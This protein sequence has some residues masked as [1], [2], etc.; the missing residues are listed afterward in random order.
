VADACAQPW[1]DDQFDL[2]LALEVLEHIDDPGAAL[3]EIARV[4]RRAA[5]ISVPNEPLW[6]VLNMARGAYLCRFGNTPGHLQHWGA[7]SFRRLVETELEIEDMR[8][9]LPWLM[10]L[11]IPPTSTTDS[12]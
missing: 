1:P 5:I 8:R 6:R 10:A 11:C 9:P 12:S 3:A 4:A 2:V 7:S